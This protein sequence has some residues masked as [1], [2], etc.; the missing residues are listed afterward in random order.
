MLAPWLNSRTRRWHWQSLHLPF[1]LSTF[2]TSPAAISHYAPLLILYAWEETRVCDL[3]FEAGGFSLR[4]TAHIA[5]GLPCCIDN[6]AGCKKAWEDTYYWG[7]NSD[8]KIRCWRKVSG[9]ITVVCEQTTW[10]SCWNM[11]AKMSQV[12]SCSLLLYIV[13][14]YSCGKLHT[15][16]PVDVSTGR[17]IWSDRL[18]FVVWWVHWPGAKEQQITS[19][20][21]N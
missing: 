6:T 1:E 5:S 2:V 8:M 13:G 3:L 9:V 7:E 21:P 14:L 12:L 10:S 4:R 20:S 18:C 11:E 16:S 15:V 17:L 19:S